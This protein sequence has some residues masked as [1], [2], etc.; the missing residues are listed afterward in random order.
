M[1]RLKGGRKEESSRVRQYRKIE[2]PA[3]TTTANSDKEKRRKRPNIFSGVG[4]SSKSLSVFRY[5][6]SG[7]FRVKRAKKREGGERE[8]AAV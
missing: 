2:V 6:F 1:N 4:S 8:S 3:Y 7:S 5:S